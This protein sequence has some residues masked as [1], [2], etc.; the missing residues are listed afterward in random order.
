MNQE[1][2]DQHQ[3]TENPHLLCLKNDT[4]HNEILEEKSTPKSIII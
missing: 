2:K 3:T 1:G 4:E